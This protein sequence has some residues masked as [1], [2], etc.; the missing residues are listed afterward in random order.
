LL[1]VNRFVQSLHTGDRGRFENLIALVKGHML[2]N[3]FVCSDLKS[4]TRHFGAVVFYFDTPLLLRLLHLEAEAASEAVAELIELVQKLSGHCAVFD[5]TFEETK[6]V[7]DNAIQNLDNPAA[8]GRV[9]EEMRRR[10]TT[11][12][13]LQLLSGRLEEALKKR[14]I[15]RRRTPKYDG[16]TSFQID[17]ASLEEAI[18]DEVE[19]MNPR[20]L[21]YDINS[22]RSIYTLRQGKAPQRLED[23]AAV[24]VTSNTALAKAA[25]A[26]GREHESTRE[27]SAVITD[28]SLAN[29]AWLKAPLKAPD[30]PEIELMAACQAALEPPPA[31][32]TRYVQE[33]DKLKAMGDI[34]AD[35]HQWL[36]YAAHARTTL[37]NLTGGS[38]GA[39]S[40][41]TV[42]EII[43]GVKA[44]IRAELAAE[45][46]QALTA[47][48]Q[49]HQEAQSQWE[50]ERQA[51]RRRLE[52]EQTATAEATE[53]AGR[54]ARAQLHTRD[55]VEAIAS[56][57]ARWCRRGAM[58]LLGTAVAA[59]IV[60]GAFQPT[61]LSRVAWMA[62]PIVLVGAILAFLDNVHGLSVRELSERIEAGVRSWAER[63]I[64]HWMIRT[65]HVD[66]PTGPTEL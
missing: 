30:L 22:V 6:G 33:V 18:A 20:A 21:Q 61:L 44:E 62:G 5:H 48:Q 35:D 65:E 16:N 46:G 55:R 15:G 53:R 39:F 19:Y 2:A 50:A 12:S 27:V 34:S 64:R 17:E 14:A 42:N 37:M 29:V 52:E 60:F 63:R 7:I 59:A 10:G 13:D 4:I 26:Y 45:V 38:E 1:T 8:R 47:E 57:V 54:L 9:I 28:F 43:G 56:N 11:K 66:R 41:K 32:W 3:A 23:A 40:G 31:L 58:L 36:R 51:L 25:F 49:K 24:L